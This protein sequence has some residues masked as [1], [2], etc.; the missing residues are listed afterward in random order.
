MI[1]RY[2]RP[3][4]GRVW[5]EESKLDKWLKV[6]LAV[7]EAWAERGV[8]PKDALPKLRRASY[9]MDAIARYLPEMHH[10]LSFLQLNLAGRR[11]PRAR[12]PPCIV[13]G[14]NTPVIEMNQEALDK[15][16]GEKKIVIVHRPQPR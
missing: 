2:T 3:Q 1:E 7:C 16:R 8:I 13:G 5:S 14:T 12:P 6:E 15:L 11:G 9:D 10:D 4:M